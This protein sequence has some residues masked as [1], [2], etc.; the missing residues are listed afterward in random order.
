MHVHAKSCDNCQRVGGIRKENKIPL[1][2]ML[3]VEV[4]DCW[5][6]KFV[7]PFP[8]SFSNEYI[9]VGVDYISKWVE[10]I[11]SQKVVGKTVI[12]FLK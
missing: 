4:F 8:P 3:E 6:I 10:A 7:G 2:S 12:E 11:A 5:G 1:Q 9:L